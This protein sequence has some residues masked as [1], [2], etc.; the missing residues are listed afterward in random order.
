M[1]IVYLVF[2]LFRIQSS[3]ARNACFV[4]SVHKHLL[5]LNC[6]VID[7]Y[8]V[9]AP[10]STSP[11]DERHEGMLTRKHEWESTTKKASHRSWDKVYCV[12]ANRQLAFYKDLKHYRAVSRIFST[13]LKLMSNLTVYR[14]V[15]VE[16]H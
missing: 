5:I 7:L 10:A 4:P 14:D 13:L 15:D 3:T 12:L 16:K 11:S 1:V 6:N 9:A 2:R 8:C